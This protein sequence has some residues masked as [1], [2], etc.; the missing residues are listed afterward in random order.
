[1]GRHAIAAVGIAWRALALGGCGASG[2]PAPVDPGPELQIVGEATVIRSGDPLPARSPWFD[3]TTVRLA[4]AHG[5]TLGIQVVRR[6]GTPPVPVTLTL[7]ASGVLVR[8]FEVKHVH[9]TRPST[10]MYGGSRGA[11]DYPDTLVAADAPASA[12]AYFE[13]TLAPFAKAGVVTGELVVG[14][15]HVPVRLEVSTAVMPPLPVESVWA[16]EDPRELG[17][18]GLPPSA[19]AQ[20]SDSERACITMFRG[21][22]VLL[23]PDLPIDA[24]PARSQLLVGAPDIPAV[25]SDDP[26]RVGDE[27][28]AWIEATRGTGQVAFAIP[29]DEPRDPAA[30]ERVHVL[31]DAV[32]AAH[33]GSRRFRYAVTAA[34]SADLLGRINLYIAAGAAHL[35]GDTVQRWTYNGRPPEAGAMVVDAAEPGMRTWG[36]IAWRYQI[37]TWYVWDALY[38]HDR[39]NRKG[40][41]LPGRALDVTRDAASFDD[42]EDHGNLDGVLAL[43]GDATT[44]CRPTLRLA[45]L[46]RG[47]EDR[48]LLDAAFACDP[49]ATKALAAKLIPRALGDAHGAA[50]SPPAWPTSDFAF[51]DARRDALLL[52]AACTNRLPR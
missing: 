6:S 3:G 11:G 45:A 36:W 24:W 43:P 25:I 12:P 21:Y 42:G 30:R 41:A 33:G 49:D 18:A 17:W 52:A 37:P 1:M 51:E 19:L 15:R 29:I 35:E 4:A 14:A 40:A 44:P 2:A 8:G 16:Y 26:A 50:G 10:D 7:V 13:I 46:R 9:V 31:A 5:E 22:G 32:H 20:P 28:R 47:L 23:S 38:W 48:A 27:V 39:H 34:P